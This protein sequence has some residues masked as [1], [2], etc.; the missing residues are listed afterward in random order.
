M[1]PSK[2]RA[3][4]RSEI[5]EAFAP[6]P[7]AEMA[8]IETL[9]ALE[10]GTRILF[11]GDKV[12][13][14][15]EKHQDAVTAIS[16]SGPAYVFYVTEAMIEAG[17]F[18]GLSDGCRVEHNSLHDLPHHAVNLG[19]NGTGRNW[20]ELNDDDQSFSSLVNQNSSERGV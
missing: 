17:V 6:L 18:L 8:R 12:V 5:T 15:P 10:T 11:G 13:R 16:G 14:V 3:Y 2:P 20:V 4:C 9:T 1:L 19:A 7:A